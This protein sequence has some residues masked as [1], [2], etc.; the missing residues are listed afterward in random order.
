MRELII[1]RPELQPKAQRV[2]WSVVT[3]VAWGFWFYFW[4]PVVSL[5][6]WIFGVHLFIE[7]MFVE[8][9]REYFASLGNYAVIVLSMA[10]VLMTWS[11]YNYTR[12]G[13]R[14][15]RKAAP[16]VERADIA[17]F[18]KVEM[19]ELIK[20][21]N[22]RILVLELSPEGHIEKITPKTLHEDTQGEQ[23]AAQPA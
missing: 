11:V 8:E 12:Y 6:A 20:S 22:H 17:E 2:V 1:N 10:A 19:D 15:R 3:L 4:L 13:K 23:A 21:Q 14:N 16:R 18:F 7:H 9:A 5:V